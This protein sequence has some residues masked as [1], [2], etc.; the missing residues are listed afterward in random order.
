V[1]QGQ[2]GELA[3]AA[4][5]GIDS[6]GPLDPTEVEADP[7]ARLAVICRFPSKWFLC[8]PSP[9]AVSRPPTPIASPGSRRS[10]SGCAMPRR[11][12]PALV[13]PPAPATATPLAPEERPA[14]EIAVAPQSTPTG[15]AYID[16]FDAPPS[17][18]AMEL[19]VGAG[20]LATTQVVEEQA[21]FDA[22]LPVMPIVLE[23]AEPPAAVEAADA[24]VAATPAPDAG[25]A[26]PPVDPTPTRL[27]HVDGCAI[28]VDR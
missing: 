1:A 22:T 6:G 2:R 25:T 21:S 28:V 23:G 26:P 9:R 20:E 12:P 13:A 3:R 10:S 19:W 5:K 16:T 7:Q 8:W 15:N 14:P 18:Q 4:A 27:L 11:H 24:T 17:Q